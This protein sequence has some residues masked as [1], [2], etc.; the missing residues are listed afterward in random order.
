MGKERI[1]STPAQARAVQEVGFLGQFFAPTSPSDAAKKLG[2]PANLAHHHAQRHLSLGLLEE[3]KR[4]GGKVLYQLTAK[5]FKVPRTL[6]PP[7]SPDNKT[8]RLLELIQT[9]FL[10]A[11]GRSSRLAEQDDPDYDLYGF[12]VKD[13][14]DPE[15]PEKFDE[16]LEPRPAHFQARTFALTPAS[17]QKL[18]R[19][20]ADLIATAEPEHARPGGGLCT[21]VFLGMDGE[22]QPGMHDSRLIS[23]FVP[24][25]EAS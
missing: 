7:E 11:Y 14:P 2:I 23:S 13:D 4:E 10:A 9:R 16:P 18:M 21:L 25:T 5:L 24:P 12:M 15:P 20:I 3:V 17:Y 8:T 22:L 1:L 19:G 6:L